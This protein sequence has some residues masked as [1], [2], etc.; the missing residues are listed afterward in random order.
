MRLFPRLGQPDPELA[1][2]HLSIGR[3]SWLTVCLTVVILPHLTRLPPWAPALFALLCG[4]RLWRVHRG[5]DR[6]PPRA[7]IVAIAIAALPAVYASIGSLTGREAGVTL[8]A[9]LSG[10][11][12]LESRGLR[13]CYVLSY[14]G[15]FLVI[16]AFL[17]DTGMLTAA[18]MLA[19]VVVMTA[20]LHALGFDPGRDPRMGVA[21]HLRRAA[22]LVLQAVPLMLVLFVLFPRIPG[23]LWGLPKDAHGG[24]TGLSDD[25]SPGNIS[26]LSQSDAVAFRVRFQ[27][28]APAGNRLYWRGPV[29]THTDGRRWTRDTGAGFARP[30]AREAL[31]G[32]VDYEVT[33]EPHGGR[34]L[35]ALDLPAGRPPGARVSTA[36]ELRAPRDVGKRM[37]YTMRSWLDYHLAPDGPLNPVAA[38]AL[39]RGRHLRA[40][41]LGLEW[42]QALGDP[43][44]VVQQ[45]LKWFREEPFRYT[46][47]PALLPGDAID[48]F[49]FGTREGFCEH[50]AGAFVVL[51]RAAG[52]P[53]RVVTGYQGGEVNPLGDYMLVRQRDAHAWTE[54]WLQGRGWVRVDPTVAVSPLRVERGIDAAIPPTVGPAGLGIEPAPAIADMLRRLRQTVDAAQASW[55]AWVLGYGPER[56]REALARVGLDAS[57]T[58]SMVL[59]LTVA[60]AV[61]LALLGAWMFLRRGRRDPVQAS[62]Q[63][64]CARLARRGL[65]RRPDEGP[66]HFARRV[67]VQRP[68]LA[69]AVHAITGRYVALRYAQR[70]DDPA[71]LA[72]AVAAFR[73]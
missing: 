60:V 11:K 69:P 42:R 55:N 46:L 35:F 68:D 26:S 43:D 51:M 65:A 18:Y 32:P 8:L 34:W 13:D 10:I 20:S 24:V 36:L 61:V 27:G 45:A 47:T 67:A 59:A 56:Q 71:A 30:G 29:L 57:S 9:V 40:R 21:T 66:L 22:V 16:T 4:W 31:G 63:R 23:P 15:F 38:L 70:P 48:D 44:A 1:G 73:P 50:Y 52:I 12:L 54:V 28:A 25:M 53:A 37:R 62:Y 33:L 58:G 72:R 3:L 17:F 19:V 6:P 64:F 2:W 5:D 41:A 14:L 49:L 7:V 39:P